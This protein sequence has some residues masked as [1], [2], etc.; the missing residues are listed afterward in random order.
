MPDGGK[1]SMLELPTGHGYH[2]GMNMQKPISLAQ[3]QHRPP[4][5]GI[6]WFVSRHPGAIE[7]A[8]RKRFAIDCWVRH[9]DPAEVAAG[10]TVIGSLPVNLAATVCRRGA[11]YFHL[12]LVVPAEWRGRE[13]SANELLALAARIEPH[14]IERIVDDFSLEVA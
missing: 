5:S 14:H 9:L 11:R 7:W 1:L 3:K 10:D 4:G 13:L 6:T 8:K 2:A 12:S